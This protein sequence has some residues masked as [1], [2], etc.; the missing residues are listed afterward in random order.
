MVEG[1]GHIP[2]HQIEANIVLKKAL[3]ADAP[4][5]VLG[6]IVTDMFPGYDHITSAIG[7]AVAGLSGADFLCSVTPSE[8]LSL[9]SV[10][11]VTDGLIAA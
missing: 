10:Q 7:V 5:Y 4:F 8:H 9:P 6:P 11:D 3:C 1:P 2:L